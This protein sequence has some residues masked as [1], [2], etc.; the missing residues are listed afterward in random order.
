MKLGRLHVLIL[1]IIVFALLFALFV[2]VISP[3]VAPN[4]VLISEGSTNW[5]VDNNPIIHG[6]T[7]WSKFA[8]SGQDVSIKL[9]YE[10]YLGGLNLNT[11]YMSWEDENGIYSASSLTLNELSTRWQV[12]ES[13][14]KFKHEDR[15]FRIS[16]SIPIENGAPKYADLEEAW[17]NKELY[18]VVEIW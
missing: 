11:E 7:L 3:P 18:Q 9:G 16:F 12:S 14:F 17:A 15:F 2:F 6:E 13:V 10:N 4:E 8:D 1:V 5:S